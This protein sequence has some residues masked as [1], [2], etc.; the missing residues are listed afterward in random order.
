MAVR[1]LTTP[2]PDLRAAGVPGALAE[3]VERAM[4]RDPSDR[5]PSAAAMRDALKA[6]D[7]AAL[8]QTERRATVDRPV[9]GRIPA[10]RPGPTIDMAAAREV[11][12]PTSLVGPAP[13]LDISAGSDVTG[14]MPVVPPAPTLDMAVGTTTAPLPGERTA[15]RPRPTP[16][17]GGRSRRDAGRVLAILALLVLLTGAAVAVLANLEQEG[18]R[19][20]SSGAPPATV[21]P[22]H[23]RTTAPDTTAAET[24]G[25]PEVVTT[26]P[27]VPTTTAPPPQGTVSAVQAVRDYYA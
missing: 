3:V 27:E 13:T 14:R 1:V 11:T 8:D 16:P 4:A 5:F 12:A 20:R 18:S 24:T 26:A 17:T 19:G 7:L 2:P 22:H 21:A 15:A 25:P 9:T 10:A 23:P 6:L